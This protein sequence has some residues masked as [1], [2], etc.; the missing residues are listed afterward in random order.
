MPVGLG[1]DGYILSYTAEPVDIPDQE[2]VDGF[3]PPLRSRSAR[4]EATG[5]M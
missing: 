2:K 1:L 5:Y 3:L 4:T